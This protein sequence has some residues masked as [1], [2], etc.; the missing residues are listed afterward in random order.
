MLRL[1]QD[2]LVFSQAQSVELSRDKPVP[3]ADLVKEA[4][5]NLKS[6]I[7]ESGAVISYDNLPAI[8]VDGA[9]FT[10]VFQNLI[11]NSIKYRAASQLPRIVISAE[12][13]GTSWIFA[14]RDNGMGFEQA[15]AE[16][17][18]GHFKRLHGKDIP[19]TGIGLAI[20]K[21]IVER[22]DGQVWAES[23]PGRGAT[24]YLRL[25]VSAAGSQGA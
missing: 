14:V 5:E 6:A 3:A 22:H 1:I 13:L 24:F 11:S 10:A 20:V 17:I 19:G 4:V 25:P 7:E 2:L 8:L 18:F 23:K 12:Q 15:Q 21:R 16:R 9:Q